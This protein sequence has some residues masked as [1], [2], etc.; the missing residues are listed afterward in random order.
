MVLMQCA[1]FCLILLLLPNIIMCEWRGSVTETT[2]KAE[3]LD[4][5]DFSIDLQDFFRSF[6]LFE[7]AVCLCFCVLKKETNM[8]MGLT[9]QT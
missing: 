4:R 5:S 6:F 3:N 8:V 1:V 9:E 7:P 2:T